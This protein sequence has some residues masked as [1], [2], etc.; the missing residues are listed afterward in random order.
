MTTVILATTFVVAAVLALGLCKTSAKG[1][2]Y[3]PKCHGEDFLL[4]LHYN[5]QGKVYNHIV[6]ICKQCK[7]LW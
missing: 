7:T 6:R 3:C 2:I 1:N 5:K 4:I